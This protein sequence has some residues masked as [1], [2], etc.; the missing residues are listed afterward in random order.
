MKSF[1]PTLAAKQPAGALHGPDSPDFLTGNGPMRFSPCKRQRPRSVSL[2]SS[3]DIYAA[4]EAARTTSTA[5]AGGTTP[6]SAVASTG[7]DAAAGGY[8]RAAATSLAAAARRQEEAKLAAIGREL[9]RTNN[10]PPRLEQ[11]PALLNFNYPFKWSFAGSAPAGGDGGHEGAAPG[12]AGP[13]ARGTSAAGG[14]IASLQ[15]YQAHLVPSARTG[16]HRRSRSWA[17]DH[18]HATARAAEGGGRGPGAARQEAGGAPGCLP[19]P[20]PVQH[21]RDSWPNAE[22]VALA[23]APARRRHRQVRARSCEPAQMRAPLALP[24]CSS[25]D[26]S[27]ADGWALLQ[28]CQWRPVAGGAAA[29]KRGPCCVWA[30][31]GDTSAAAVAEAAAR[32]A[33][34]RR[35]TLELLSAGQRG[36]AMRLLTE[37]GRVARRGAGGSIAEMAAGLTSSA[38]QQESAASSPSTGLNKKQHAQENVLLDAIASASTASPRTPVRRLTVNVAP[39]AGVTVLAG[40]HPGDLSDEGEEDS[41]ADEAK[42]TRA[43]DAEG[44][45]GGGGS[46]GSGKAKS[47][48]HSCSSARAAE[49]VH[50]ALGAI[51]D[52][53]RR[54][55]LGLIRQAHRHDAFTTAQARELKRRADEAG[56]VLGAD[57]DDAVATSTAVAATGSAVGDESDGTGGG[58]ALDAQTRAWNY[59]VLSAVRDTVWIACHLRRAAEPIPPR[60]RCGLADERSG[61]AALLRCINALGPEQTAEQLDAK[62]TTLMWLAGVLRNWVADVR[63]SLVAEFG[64][65]GRAVA[66]AAAAARVAQREGLGEACGSAAASSGAGSGG[67]GDLF[68]GGS[69]R[70]GVDSW[71][72][73]IDVV[74]LA[75][76]FVR[77]DNHFFGHRGPYAAGNTLSLVQRLRAM[78]QVVAMLAIDEASVPLINLKLQLVDEQGQAVRGLGGGVDTVE[79]DL[80][81]SCYALGK[82]CARDKLQG[83]EH[84]HEEEVEAAALVCDTVPPDIRVDDDDMIEHMNTASLLALNG[85]RTATLLLAL[86]PD[87]GAFRVALR[88][89]RAWAKARGVYSHKHGYLSGINCAILVGLV[90]QQLPHGSSA[91]LVARFFEL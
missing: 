81:L 49:L 58:V 20:L 1:T 38:L 23:D 30:S 14:S 8:S 41:D 80:M 22:T 64:E 86:V 34:L 85:P 37:A 54:A 10:M 63:A 29:Q 57:E 17:P 18:V 61:S 71:S 6:G 59:A 69:R 40:G 67:N 21:R 87:A 45:S 55:L 35:R 3:A 77:A 36:A 79:L 4:V 76:H 24:P 5:V 84:I 47:A 43:G 26:G 62:H 11:Q 83:L 42:A 2:P 51:E 72:T 7:A 68:V 60:L 48:S 19:P 12:A 25:D 31:A 78:P 27:S 88:A 82:V 33:D 46:S 9:D 44:S 74:W 50:I 53:R 13:V 65:L 66:T 15:R 28:L 73:D 16:R 90:C 32:R 75:P 89:V 39:K 52:C 70:L 56:R 91:A